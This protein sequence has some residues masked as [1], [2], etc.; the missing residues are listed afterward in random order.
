MPHDITGGGIPRDSNLPKE[1]YANDE[2]RFPNG[3]M[4]RLQ[5]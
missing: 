5:H 2:I 1:I 4:H 3:C